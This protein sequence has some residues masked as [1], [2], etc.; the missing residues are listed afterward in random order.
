MSPQHP[1]EIMAATAIKVDVAATANALTS[2]GRQLP[3][4]AATAL[5]TLAFQVQRAE[6][7]GISQV[8][9]HPRPFT[10]KAVQVNR[11]SKSALAATVFIRPEVAKYLQPYETGG[12]HV[13]PGKALLDP[14]DIRLDQYGQL[15][16]STMAILR[17][18]KDI[19]IGPITT[20]SGVVTGVWQRLAVTRKGNAR[21]KRLSGGGVYDTQRGALKLLI[22]FGDA[23]EV[24][25]QLGFRV[26]GVAL[27]LANA[28]VAFKTAITKAL[29][30]AR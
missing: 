22:R 8:L 14:V 12:V 3:F 16:Q 1:G 10:A 19:Y 9:A 25:K 5:N 13:L 24:K 15:P 11:A 17:A 6:I 20:K 7:V 23:V 28:G 30:T 2:I 29:V 4:A 18:R 26:R 27:V 21:R